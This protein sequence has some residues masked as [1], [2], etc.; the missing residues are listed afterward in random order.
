MFHPYS[1]EGFIDFE[2][3]MDPDMRKAYETHVREF[4]QTPRQLFRNLHPRKG[5]KS[6][7]QIS[8]LSNNAS[9][10]S[11][12]DV[13]SPLQPKNGQIEEEKVQEIQPAIPDQ[14]FSGDFQ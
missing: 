8:S 12:A 7:E 10:F 14:D 4:G 6:Y 2:Q 1:Y 9:S 5:Q 3:E 11:L 13:V